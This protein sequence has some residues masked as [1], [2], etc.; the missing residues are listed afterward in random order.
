[1]STGNCF[2]RMLS[3]LEMKHTKAYA[4]QVYEANP[5]RNT[6]LGFT[7]MFARY[8]IRT[9]CYQFNGDITLEEFPQPF[10]SIVAGEFFTVESLCPEGVKGSFE[11]RTE[12]IPYADFYKNWNRR[13]LFV[14]DIESAAEPDWLKN[15]KADLLAEGVGA[16][17][18]LAFLYQITYI[19]LGGEHIV[20]H[21]VCLTVNM[22]GLYLSYLTL[23][24]T[25]SAVKH[26]LCSMVKEADCDKV[27]DSGGGTLLGFPLGSIG[28]SYFLSGFLIEFY[29]PAF[30]LFTLSANSSHLSKNLRNNWKKIFQ[31]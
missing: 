28:I 24:Q 19:T 13:S 27:H 3:L 20:F 21:L 4:M 8:G 25:N 6:L 1:M 16:V 22:A 12:V 30:S 11:E 26:K 23:T 5:R 14:T 29:L 15:K 10:L 31:R 7:E 18:L 9:E 2:L 17:F